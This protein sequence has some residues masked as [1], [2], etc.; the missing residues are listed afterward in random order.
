MPTPRPAP[1]LADPRP[2]VGPPRPGV[3]TRLHF[4]WAAFWGVVWTALLSPGVIAHSALR[5]GT[6][7]F[8]AWMTPWGRLVLA[9]GGYRLHVEDRAR[10]APGAPVV[11]VANHQN[12]LDIVTASAGVPY[13]FGF[14][15]KAGLRRFPLIGSVLKHTA[16]LFV[17]R[18]TPRRAAETIVV[19]ARHLREGQSVLL[20]P[21]GGR[22]WSRTM[23]PFMKGAFLLAIEAEVPLVP[24]TF[25]DNAVRLDERRWTARPGRL[26][27]VVGEPLSTAGLTRAEAPALAEAARRAMA[28]ELHRAG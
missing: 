17:D 5:P 15:A 14:A 2:G 27:V 4:A 20:F 1:S 24:V 23:K 10:L 26:R 11:F 8:K 19:G 21:E 6:R 28:R 16:C 18:S 13:P 12:A 9:C 3:G 22:S 25:L 7:T